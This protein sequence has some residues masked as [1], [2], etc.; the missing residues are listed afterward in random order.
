MSSKQEYRENSP[1]I[2]AYNFHLI[3]VVILTEFPLQNRGQGNNHTHTHTHTHTHIYIYI[4]ISEKIKQGL[5]SKSLRE[6][7]QV[8]R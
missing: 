7:E 1:Y 4:Y 6:L 2:C 8:I 3:Y 5:A